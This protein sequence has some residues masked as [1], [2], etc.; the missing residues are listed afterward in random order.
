MSQQRDFGAYFKCSKSTI[1]DET[2]VVLGISH[3][4]EIDH[5]RQKSTIPRLIHYTEIDHLRQENDSESN[6][7]FTESVSGLG[8]ATITAAAE[9]TCPYG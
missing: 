1:S 7:L 3:S 5:L 2:N 9:G 4:L 6:L 8:T